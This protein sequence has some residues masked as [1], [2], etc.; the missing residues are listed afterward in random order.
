MRGYGTSEA[1]TAFRSAVQRGMRRYAERTKC[2]QCGRKSALT[3]FE[4]DGIRYVE[5]RW[6]ARGLC[7]YRRRTSPEA[8]REGER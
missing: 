2:P 6:K 1:Q 4:I 7:D 8:G 3:R 5:C